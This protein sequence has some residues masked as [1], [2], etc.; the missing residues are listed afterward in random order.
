MPLLLRSVTYSNVEIYKERPAF[1]SGLLCIM[2]FTLASEVRARIKSARILF[3]NS[4]F[5]PFLNFLCTIVQLRFKAAKV[6]KVA[7]S[8]RNNHDFQNCQLA[9]DEEA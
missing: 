9:A 4:I 6:L 1:S 5:L 8:F 7:L 3:Q 2:W